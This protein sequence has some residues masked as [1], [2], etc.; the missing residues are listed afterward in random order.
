MDLDRNDLEYTLKIDNP[1]AVKK[2]LQCIKFKNVVALLI[3]KGS[4]L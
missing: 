3:F 2:L 1:I 4:K